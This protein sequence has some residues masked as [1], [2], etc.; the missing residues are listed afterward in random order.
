MV[1][2][3]ASRCTC[4]PAGVRSGVDE[5]LHTMLREVVA[6]HRDEPG[7]L[8]QIL[9]ET[10]NML[11]YLPA[12]VQEVI[13]AE[14]RIPVTEVYGVVT[15]Y[16]YFTMKPRGLHVVRICMGTACYVR[17]AA[18]LLAQVERE[19]GIKAPGTTE[20]GQFT[21]ETV[22]C[23]GACSLAPVMLVDTRVHREVKPRQIAGLLAKCRD[24]GDN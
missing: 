14:L 15:F 4:A 18:E 20:D 24:G 1:L 22:R 2:E 16:S 21:V 13:A 17:G 12:H 3:V 5:P 9:H 10:Q 19:L 11:G 6:K 23:L 7:S 8:I